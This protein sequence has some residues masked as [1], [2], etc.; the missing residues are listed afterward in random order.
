MNKTNPTIAGERTHG[1]GLTHSEDHEQ[2]GSEPF[3]P[4]SERGGYL[5]DGKTAQEWFNLH[6]VMRKDFDR[7][8]NEKKEI[9]QKVRDLWFQAGLILGIKGQ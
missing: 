6:E 8:L 4:G 5:F 3:Y 1:D 7:L 2:T 9:E